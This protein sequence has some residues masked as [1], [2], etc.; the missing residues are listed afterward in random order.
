MFISLF[1]GCIDKEEKQL[2]QEQIRYKSS[3]NINLK[4]KAGKMT[5]DITIRTNDSAK[6]AQ[7]WIPYPS[8]NKNQEIENI[9]INGNYNY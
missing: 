8:S 5:F 4:E 2:K 7:L 1:A 3:G 6:K 9:T